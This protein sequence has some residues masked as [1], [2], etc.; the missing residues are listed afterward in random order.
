MIIE[1]CYCLTKRV[2]LNILERQVLIIPDIKY[3][4]D[5]IYATANTR[6]II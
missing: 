6:K 4:Y 3:R 1:L 5:K 2:Q